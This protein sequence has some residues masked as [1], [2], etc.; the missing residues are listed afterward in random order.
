MSQRFSIIESLY[1]SPPE[2]KI[3]FR[4]NQDLVLFRMQKMTLNF[5]A[6]KLTQNLLNMGEVVKSVTTMSIIQSIPVA[7]YTCCKI[8]LN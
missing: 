1:Y 8:Y 4:L 7:K 3:E 6:L 2:L 5:V